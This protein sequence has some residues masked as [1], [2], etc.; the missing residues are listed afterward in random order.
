M[1]LADA[2]H[3]VV[4]VHAHILLEGV[5]NTCGHAGPEM[6]VR[7]DGTQFF[8]AA[9]YVLENVK[10]V[11]SAFSNAQMRI[12]Q[13]DALGLD[14]QL[15][16]PNPITYFY[17]Q[18][19]AD[20]LSFHQRTNDEIALTGD[21]HPRLLGAAT[22]P[23]QSP[24]EACKELNRAVS[25]LGLLCSYIGT[26]INGTPL[27]HPQ[28]EELWAEHERLG[29]PVVLHPEPRTGYGGSDPF[30][31]P[32]D[33]DIIFGFA[34]DEG[35]AVAHFLFSGILDRHPGLHV[36]VAHGGGFAAFQ[37]G[38]LE[39]AL[40]RRPWGK[41]LLTRPFADQWAQIS[42]D[43]A[44]HRQDA[45]AF[46]VETEGPDKVLL[47]SNFAGW[48]LEDKYMEKIEALQLSASDTAKILGG[49]AKRIFKIG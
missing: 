17:H 37:K 35:L 39:Q 3:E 11:N 16:S 43:T 4:D 20:A 32:W 12:E 25:E 23:M 19:I 41:G 27:S 45:L 15:V 29:V 2:H 31:D 14:K 5:M 42:F 21:R 18:P 8:R 30:F 6:G 9:D 33:L 26:D 48:D 49:N 34:M 46:L 13:M 40:E 1:T 7:E 47:G 44:V 38:R 10:F 22:L 24:E 28:F 36:H